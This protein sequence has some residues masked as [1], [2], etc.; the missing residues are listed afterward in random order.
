MHPLDVLAEL[1]GELAPHPPV[2]LLAHLALVELEQQLPPR[3]QLVRR[4]PLA[5]GRRPR[6]ARLLSVVDGLEQVLLIVLA[7]GLDERRRGHLAPLA[8]DRRA[9]ELGRG[10][11]LRSVLLL[12]LLG[13][14]LA[15]LARVVELFLEV[16]LELLVL[17]HELPLRLLVLTRAVVQQHAVVDNVHQHA[18]Q[19]ELVLKAQLAVVAVLQPLER[20]GAHVALQPPRAAALVVLGRAEERGQHCAQVAQ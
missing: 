11:R 19:R 1:L 18:Q 6:E 4:P 20:L 3:A 15:R 7:D 5:V 10:R 13:L 2:L 9:V 12:H 8:L 16:G 17:L 14:V